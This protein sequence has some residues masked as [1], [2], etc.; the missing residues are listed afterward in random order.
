MCVCVCVCK[1][2]TPLTSEVWCEESD[3]PGWKG[4]VSLTVNGHRKPNAADRKLKATNRKRPPDAVAAQ[5]PLRDLEEQHHPEDERRQHR[6]D[7]DEL[8]VAVGCGPRAGTRLHFHADV[9]D[10][11]THLATRDYE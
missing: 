6:R 7:G 10:Q 4:L 1:H 3:A 2:H 11:R 5:D 8:E 9:R